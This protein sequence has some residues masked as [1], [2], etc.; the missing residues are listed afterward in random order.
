VPSGTSA[1]SRRYVGVPGPRPA[2]ARI[3]LIVA[4]PTRCPKAE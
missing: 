1:N 3:R 2:R 4:A